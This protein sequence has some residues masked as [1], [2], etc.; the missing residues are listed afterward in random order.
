LFGFDR[1]W[2]ASFGLFLVRNWCGAY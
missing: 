1:V 2:S